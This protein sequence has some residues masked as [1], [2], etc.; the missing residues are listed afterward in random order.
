MLAF[1]SLESI[2]KKIKSKE[3]SSKEVFDYFLKRIEK[4]D[5]K[6]EAF[7]YVNK[8]FI[9]KTDSLLAWIPISIK[10]LYAEKWILTTWSSIML[11]DFETF[12]ESSIIRKL[13]EAWM[14][15]IWKVTLDEF[16][17]WAS[18]ENSALKLAKNPWDLSRIAWGSSSWSAASVA[19]GLCPASLWTDTWWS[20]RFPWWM[21]WVV[22]FRPWY[23][24]NSRYWIYPMASSLDCPWTITR[25]VRDAWILY[26]LMNWFDEFDNT[27]IPWKQ[28]LD[29]KIW[30]K[31]NLKWIKLWVPKEYFE[32]W[33]DEN[34]R[35]TINKAI[36]NLK[37]L[38]AE[39]IEISLPT[40]K[41]AIAAY[42]IIV[43]AEVSTNLARLDWIRYWHLSSLPHENLEEFYINNRWEWLWLE[44]KRRSIL[45]AYVLS[46][47]FYEAYFMKAAK[48]RTLIIEDFK[49]AFE[50]VDLIV[51]PVSPS[52][53]WKIWEKTNDPLKMY[54]ADVYTCPA[55]LAW[56][57]WISIPCWLAESEDSEKKNL[58]VWLQIIW[59][60]LWEEKL[61][62][63]AHIY[64]QN[65]TW[66][67]DLIPSW[68]ED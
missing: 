6:I 62:E 38:W 51:S 33:L 44:S 12:Y 21:C 63:L 5:S 10:D 24:R 30:N 66:Y 22:W 19:A 14:N 7:N 59:P 58:P 15:S 54:M 34:V 53:A 26:D 52:V 43:W 45:W 4:Y 46:A 39:I 36:Q 20:L 13:N 29:E 1:E 49:K 68:F 50:K 47:W 56:L 27:S 64:E 18:W 41:Y 67:K 40:T 35:K 23:W 25:T 61:F 32:D 31:E 17:M 48:V 2:I 65:N 11:Q 8:N 16:A 57:P 60:Q 42:Y 55:S 3:I 28:K 37:D 9:D